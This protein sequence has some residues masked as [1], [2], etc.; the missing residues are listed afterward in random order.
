[1]S[2]YSKYYIPSWIFNTQLF[3]TDYIKKNNEKL[4]FL[5][6]KVDNDFA[7][8]LYCRRVYLSYARYNTVIWYGINPFR[9]LV[10][11]LITIYL[12]ATCIKNWWVWSYSSYYNINLML[13]LFEGFKNGFYEILYR[14]CKWRNITLVVEKYHFQSFHLRYL[15]FKNNDWKAVKGNIF[16]KFHVIFFVHVCWVNNKKNLI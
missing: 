4:W 11:S 8:L 2:T 1:M 13:V 9:A 6:D 7:R 12:R 3:N 15:I 10:D 5:P 16:L 14:E